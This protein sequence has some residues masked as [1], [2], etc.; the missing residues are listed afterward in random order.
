MFNKFDFT[1]DKK[2]FRGLPDYVNELHKNGQKY[3][4]IV[5]SY[6]ISKDEHLKIPSMGQLLFEQTSYIANHSF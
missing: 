3:I 4:V 6:L 1:Y 2:T 5:V